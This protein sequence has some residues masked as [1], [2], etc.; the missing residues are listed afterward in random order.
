M[1]D[2]LGQNFRSIPCLVP[3]LGCVNFTYKVH[4]PQTS[5]SSPVACMKLRLMKIGQTIA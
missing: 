5:A 3:E 1:S 2:V 4:V